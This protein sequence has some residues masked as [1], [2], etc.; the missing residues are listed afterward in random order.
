M[1][2]PT[3]ITDQDESD[4]VLAAAI[5]WLKAEGITFVVKNKNHHLKVGKFNFYPKRGTI[6]VDDERAKRTEHG[7]EQFKELIG[8]WRGNLHKHRT[9]YNQKPT[10]APP[11]RNKTPPHPPVNAIE[12]KLAPE[13]NKKA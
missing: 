5:E 9:A 12:L 8:E 10:A 2:D 3:T 4:M 1:L 7:L 6:F 13:P 11:F